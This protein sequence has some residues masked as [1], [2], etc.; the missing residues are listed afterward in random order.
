VLGPTRYT[1][2]TTGGNR[3]PGID[4]F[5][6]FMNLNVT[7]SVV[8]TPAPIA[9]KFAL[10]GETVFRETLH[11]TLN[12]TD[13]TTAFKPGP[14][15][16]ADLVGVFAVGTTSPLVA[17][18]NILQTSVEGLKTGTTQRATDVDKI[19]FTL[20]PNAQSGP[21]LENVI[22]IGCTTFQCIPH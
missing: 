3:R 5:L 21:A 7:G 1:Q 11:I 6:G 10:N 15:D 19:T 22:V 16:G 14:S 12:G 2:V 9:L 18:K 8:R 13:V 4:G 20:D 17:G